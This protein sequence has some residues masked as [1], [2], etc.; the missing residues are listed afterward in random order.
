MVMHLIWLEIEDIF[1]CFYLGVRQQSPHKHSEQEAD[2]TGEQTTECLYR[3]PKLSRSVQTFLQNCVVYINTYRHPTA[4]SCVWV[5]LY[6]S[7]SQAQSPEQICTD[8]PRVLFSQVKSC[9]MWD[10]WSV[11]TEG[12]D[13]A[14]IAWMVDKQMSQ[15]F[16]L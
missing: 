10:V 1:F 3:Q 11:L 2:R 14:V 7:V 13:A 5:N 12:L 15:T 4:Q 8:A 6:K 16:Y 9:E